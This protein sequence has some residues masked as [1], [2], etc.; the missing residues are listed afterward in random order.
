MVFSTETALQLPPAAPRGTREIGGDAP[1]RACALRHAAVYS[2]IADDELEKLFA[3]GT[4]IS[5]R[6]GQM[7][8]TEGDPA[9]V[10]YSITKGALMVYKMTRDGRR[11]ITGFLYEGDLLGLVDEGSYAYSAEA[12]APTILFGYPMRET[13]DLIQRY[14]EVE[15]RLGRITR[16][17]LVENQEQML[18]LGRKTA[19]ERVASFLLKLLRQAKDR[20]VQDGSI[21]IPMTRE[22]MGDYLGLTTETVSRVLSAFAREK[23]VAIDR[24]DSAARLLNVDYIKNIAEGAPPER[25][26]ASARQKR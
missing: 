20:G 7:L 2:S 24:S 9:T 22:M 1:C 8:F 12:I 17:E 15:R 5:L 14:P 25:A 16:Q 10:L 19:R 6:R 3:A 11:Q 23:L 4:E 18:L 21:S 26:S 13:E